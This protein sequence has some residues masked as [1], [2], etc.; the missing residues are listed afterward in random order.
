VKIANHEDWWRMKLIDVL[1]G[2]GTVVSGIG[3][4]QVQYDLEVYESEIRGWVRPFCGE[5][6]VRNTLQM[7]DG[8][9]VRFSFIDSNGMV[10]A[11][12]GIIPA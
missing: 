1:K 11:S 2:T 7:Q 6:G 5:K 8:T 4:T 9:S 3:N 10:T 12:G